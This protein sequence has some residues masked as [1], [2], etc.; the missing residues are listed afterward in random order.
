[1][2]QFHRPTCQTSGDTNQ[3]HRHT[4]QTSGD[5]NQLNRPTSQTSGE[6]NELNRHTFKTSGDTN[7]F[8][9]MTSETSGDVNG[10]DGATPKTSGVVNQFHRPTSVTSGP[11]NGLARATPKTSS[12]QRHAVGFGLVC[13]T[14]AER[15]PPAASNPRAMQSC[16][17]SCPSGSLR[18]T[19]PRV[20]VGKKPCA[21]AI[22]FACTTLTSALNISVLLGRRK[23]TLIA[24][25]I[26]RDQ[27]RSMRHPL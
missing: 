7:Q 17:D 18:S 24:Q 6:T 1:M 2:N 16:S 21:C 15:M 13:S 10:L 19:A 25:A 4:S 23:P 26:L 3:L 9:G 5:T 14:K 12:G 22:A 20:K 27:L 8:H 11:F